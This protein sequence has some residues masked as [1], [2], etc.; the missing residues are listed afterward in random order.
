MYIRYGFNDVTLGPNTGMVLVADV[1]GTTK[2]NDAY[3]AERC[4]SIPENTPF[5]VIDMGTVRFSYFKPCAVARVRS[6]LLR[7]STTAALLSLRIQV[8]SLSSGVQTFF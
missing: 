3:W 1:A 8:C 6:Q 4:Q 2:A 7:S 5:I